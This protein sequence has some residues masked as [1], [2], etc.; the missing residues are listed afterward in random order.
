MTDTITKTKFEEDYKGLFKYRLGQVAQ[1]TV[2]D[3]E[4]FGRITNM[5]I[6]IHVSVDSKPL[7]SVRIQYTIGHNYNILE[8]DIIQVYK[9]I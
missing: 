6:S 7:L 9:Q 5:D 4:K 1:F 8:K 2:N 3:T